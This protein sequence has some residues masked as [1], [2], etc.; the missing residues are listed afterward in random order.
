MPK[1]IYISVEGIV[2]ERDLFNWR[3]KVTVW[4]NRSKIIETYINIKFYIFLSQAS[5]IYQ[6]NSFTNFLEQLQHF[7]HDRYFFA[8]NNNIKERSQQHQRTVMKASFW[9]FLGLNLLGIF[10]NFDCLQ[11]LKFHNHS[12]WDI[13]K[14]GVT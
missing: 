2:Q 1:L 4:S 7:Q 3:I 6:M 13:Y 11:N 14:T 5:K 8:M 12:I 10:V 9:G